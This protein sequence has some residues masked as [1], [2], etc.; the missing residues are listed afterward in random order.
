[1]VSG[2]TTPP[3]TRRRLGEV[4]V[5]QGAITPEQLDTALDAQR[6]AH[7]ERRRVRLGALVAELGFASDRQVATALASALSLEVVDLATVSIDATVTRLLPRSL[8]ER[9]LVLPIRRSDSGQVTI[10][11]ADPTNVV[12]IDDVKVYAG[13]ADVKVVVAPESQVRDLLART[14]SL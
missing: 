14:W 7:R 3:A 9:H 2:S 4:L 5:E 13:I 10:A 1:M 12:A 11:C 8:A 6:V